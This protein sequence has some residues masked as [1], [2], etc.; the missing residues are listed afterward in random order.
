MEKQV[1]K[2]LAEEDKSINLVDILMYLL[3][4]W[5]WYVLSILICGGY[6]WYDYSRTPFVYSRSAT[7]MIKTPANTPSAIRLIRSGDY[8]GQVNMATERLQFQSKALMRKVISRLNADVSYA[9]R[10]GLRQKELYMAA[11]VRV[12]FLVSEPE[13][14]LSLLV[15]PKN[16]RQVELS[17]F[18]RGAESRKTVNIN[19]TVETALGRLVVSATENYDSSCWGKPVKVSKQAREKMVYFFLS[20]LSIKQVNGDVALLNIM[21]DDFSPLRAGD[22]L[23]M[24]IT[25]YN[26]EAIEDKNRIAVNAA[27]FIRER[28]EIIEDELGSVE[29]D[30]E[31]M[32][33]E[34]D[35]GDINTAA[36]MYVSDGRKYESSLKELDTQ[37]QLVSFIKQYLQDAAKEDELIPGDIGLTDAVIEG[38]IARYNEAL[39]RRNRLRSGSGGNHPVVQELTRSVET[40][41]QNINRSIN[42]Q[43]TSL[44]LKRTEI[45][46]QERLARRKVRDVPGKQREMLSVE[47][48]QKV[49]ESLYLFLL[50]KREENALNQSMVD[51]N[52]RI[53][54]SASGSNAPFYPNKY[55]KLLL[56][57]GMGILIPTVILLLILIVDTRVR[58][59]KDMEAVVSAPFLAE[60][61]KSAEKVTEINDIMVRARGQD[62]LSE[63][64]RI[65][66]TNLGFVASQSPGQKVVTLTS[67][68][69]SAGKTFV[70]VNLS[71]S[72]VQ[73]DKKV[74]L[75]DLDL[76]KATLS[77]IAKARGNGI[78][79]MA[80]Y[81]SNKS[82]SMDDIIMKDGFGERI[83]LIPVG[84]IA[85]NPAE[86]LLSGRLDELIGHL[87]ERY[88]YNCGWGTGWDGGGCFYQ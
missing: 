48:Q 83:D 28:I 76:R 5:K 47:R 69:V 42:N 46:G 44:K 21:M 13:A 2:I 25:V 54:D 62:A 9:V 49:K 40:M 17:D 18:S 78:K 53:I 68:N 61:P 43:V 80:H 65:L 51:N 75:I 73:A 36:S 87:R 56:G 27:Q 58:N 86:L 32:R 22:V 4:Y 8:M 64:F 15:T 79:G 74:I 67:F 84:V 19:D 23:N 6:F 30:I 20:N 3:S 45:S 35:W 72:L 31:V 38:Q 14:E 7:V 16:E 26:E 77:L 81:L 88:D 52:A 39:L 29:T 11:P 37:L 70:S 59:R 63:S 33:K 41:R 85:P 50:N 57:G 24:L 10:D 60:I 34:S 71:A 55:K 66:R 82:I 12:H 1:K